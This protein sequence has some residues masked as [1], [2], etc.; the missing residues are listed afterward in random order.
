VTGF[1][2]S[3][4]DKL[5]NNRLEDV[6]FAK[7]ERAPE[8]APTTAGP[9]STT[10]H[11]VPGGHGGKVLRSRQT[12]THKRS[13]RRRI[14]RSVMMPGACLCPCVLETPVPAHCCLPTGMPGQSGPAASAARS[15]QPATIMLAM[16]STEEQ[17]VR[18]RVRTLPA[19][20]MKGLIARIGTKNHD[21]RYEQSVASYFVLY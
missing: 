7:K 4:R 8:G 19:R 2:A 10:C 16:S 3:P 20:C 13:R 14:S 6:P 17:P 9:R 5:E 21:F 11:T 15:D 18:W 12:A 1:C